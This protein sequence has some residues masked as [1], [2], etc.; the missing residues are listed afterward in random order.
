MPYDLEPH[1]LQPLKI[2]EVTQLRYECPLALD[3]LST[4]NGK[5][6]TTQYLQTLNLMTGPEIPIQLLAL[7]R[8][9]LG[10]IEPLFVVQMAKSLAQQFRRKHAHWWGLGRCSSP[11]PHFAHCSM[12]RLIGMLHTACNQCIAADT[13]NF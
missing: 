8:R 5:T 3:V 12:C 9:S 10:L 4:N 13:N 6:D 7:G 2:A 1:V 11:C